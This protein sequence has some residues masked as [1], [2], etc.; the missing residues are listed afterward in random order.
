MNSRSSFLAHAWG[1]ACGIHCCAI[2]I[3]SSHDILLNKQGAWRRF[4][5]CSLHTPQWV[6]HLVE[7]VVL[8]GVARRRVAR[9]AMWRAAHRSAQQRRSPECMPTRRERY[10][11]T[12][13]VVDCAKVC[14]NWLLYTVQR[15]PA[16]AIGVRPARCWALPSCRAAMQ[17]SDPRSLPAQWIGFLPQIIVFLR[18]CSAAGSLVRC[19]DWCPPARDAY[20]VLCDC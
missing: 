2:S 14:V 19:C 7:G 17:C 12:C 15:R 11:R 1:R 6:H 8:R 18:A 5:A 20:R 16:A 3:G 10:I 4:R 9:P 13:V